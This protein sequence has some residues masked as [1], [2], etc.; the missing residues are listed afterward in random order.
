MKPETMLKTML[1]IIVCGA[2]LLGYFLIDGTVVRPIIH[3]DG[4]LVTTRAIYH[5]GDLVQAKVRFCKYRNIPATVQWTLSNDRLTFYTPQ[6]QS[7][8][9]T[10][11]FDRITDIEELS[12]RALP[13][14]YHFNG[15]LIYQVNPL[16]KVIVNIRTTPFTVQ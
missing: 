1:G 6:V 14:A 10:G 12:P 4:E 7:I 11:C 8:G 16:K 15:T 9:T 13:G 5:P 3:F 2:L